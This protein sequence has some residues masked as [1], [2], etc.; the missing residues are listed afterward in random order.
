MI[1]NFRGYTME[2]FDRKLALQTTKL[3][4]E[5][6]PI[7][8]KASHLCFPTESSFLSFLLPVVKAF[9]GKDLRTRM[10]VHVGLPDALREGLEEFGLASDNL[11]NTVGGTR[12]IQ[13]HREWLDERRHLERIR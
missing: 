13:K 11:P 6:L 9:V 2:H 10:I 5:C 3:V 8:I 1:I 12:A 4:K 7:L